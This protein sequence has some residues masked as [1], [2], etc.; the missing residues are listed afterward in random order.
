MEAGEST[1]EGGARNDRAGYVRGGRNGQTDDEGDAQAMSI[2]TREQIDGARKPALVIDAYVEIRLDRQAWHR[3]KKP[4][5]GVKEADQAYLLVSVP[6]AIEIARPLGEL[7]TP[8]KSVLR[9]RHRHGWR[10]RAAMASIVEG[11]TMTLHVFTARMGRWMKNDPCAMDITQK[12]ARE[13]LFL[14]PSWTILRPAL[15]ARTRADTLLKE[16]QAEAK[17]LGGYEDK[18]GLPT[19][20]PFTYQH[21][22]EAITD[23]AWSI[24]KSQY[25]AE[26]RIS[27]G[28]K[29]DHR[30]WTDDTQAA[31]DRGVRPSPADWR[32]LLGLTRVILCCYCS[33][34]AHCH[35]TILRQ[36]ILPTLGAEDCG[37]FEPPKEQRR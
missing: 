5:L 9:P 13:G 2:P 33:D 36:D 35:R 20:D 1:S 28:M 15:E 19:F 4:E 18:D 32:W 24:Y 3:L 30:Q 14:A 26:M 23:G 10:G 12:S 22:A 25:V 21:E 37:E 11:S 27:I 6:H 29:P 17:R 16:C 34:I 31:W 7:H 8:A